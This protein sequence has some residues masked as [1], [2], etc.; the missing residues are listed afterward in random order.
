MRRQVR[1]TLDFF[2]ALDRALPAERSGPVPSRRDFEVR[3]LVPLV[4][5]IAEH[6]DGLV[7]LIRGR[8]D[9]RQH[10][11]WSDLGVSFVVE[12][13]IAKDGA[14][15]LVDIDIQTHPPSDDLD[16]AY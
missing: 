14:V 2:E 6:W 13:Q 3:E 10:W 1:L 11:G 5:F 8:E 9:Y 4:E 15:E 16:D 7:P 12:G